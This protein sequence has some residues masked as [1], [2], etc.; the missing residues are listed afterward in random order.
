VIADFGLAY[1][2]TSQLSYTEYATCWYRAPE[3][4]L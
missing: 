3:V 4:L 2:I 1:E